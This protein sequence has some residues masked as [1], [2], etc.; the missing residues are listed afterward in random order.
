MGHTIAADNFINLR[1]A[2]DSGLIR[3][4]DLL[5][6]FTFGYGLNWSCMV[7]EH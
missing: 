1:D 3:K 5:L 4:G 7:V 2:T 6:L